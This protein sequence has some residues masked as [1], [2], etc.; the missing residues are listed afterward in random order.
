[1]KERLQKILAN[2]GIASR[3]SAETLIKQG[4]VRIDGQVVT[5]MG[6]KVD[7]DRHKIECDGKTVT[8]T[9]EKIYI[10]L[11]KPKGYVTTMSDPQGRPIVTSLL[12]NISARLFP[13]GRLDLE[14]EGALILTN[15]GELAQQIQHP[16]YEVNK[17]Y[18]AVVQGRPDSIK[19]ARLQKGIILEGK[20]TWPAKIKIIEKKRHDTTIMITIHEGKKRQVRKMFAAVGHRVINLKRTAY[21]GLLLGSLKPG[22]Y[23]IL[24]KKELNLIFEK[25]RPQVNKVS[26]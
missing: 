20:K 11:N 12:K 1:M 9:E 23:R 18:E 14:T 5:E 26:I 21:G 4:R 24:K 22:K 7:P 8:C 3:R 15:D 10:L 19:I 17:T 6:I 25:N 16:S 13:V 2:A